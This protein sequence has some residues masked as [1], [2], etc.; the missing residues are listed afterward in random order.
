MAPPLP[1]LSTIRVFDAAARHLNFTAAGEELAMTQAAV[2]YQIRLLEEWA[3]TRLFVRQARGV[4]LSEAGARLAPVVDRA[5]AELREGFSSLKQ[6]QDEVLS[7]SAVATFSTT[8]LVPRLGFF[9]LAHP[10]IA[11]RLDTSHHLT[12]FAREEIDLGIRVGAGKW[13][14]LAAHWVLPIR[15]SPMLGP[16]LAAR[17][18]PAPKPADLLTLPIIDPPDPWWVEWFAAAGAEAGDL[19][20]RPGLQLLSQ[21]LAARAAMADQ[22]VAILEPAFFQEELATGRLVQPFPALATSD[23]SYY[24]VFPEA[25]RVPRKVQ[26]FLDWLKA[27]LAEEAGG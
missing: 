11:V 16:G 12:D 13:P 1:P 27:R 10:E 14:G 4:E 23:W 3:G 9:Q 7:I 22:G 18:G 8:W 19:A 6:N 2:S 20:A 17:L 26:V 24:V 21:H 15:F 5:L 25:R